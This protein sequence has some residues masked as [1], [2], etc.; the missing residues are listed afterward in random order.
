MVSDVVNLLLKSSG[1]FF[2]QY[3]HTSDL[4]ILFFLYIT[5]IAR[6]DHTDIVSHVIMHVK[7]ILKVRATIISELDERIMPL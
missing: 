2:L 3:H 5:Y 4:Q 6:Y 1:F 7:K